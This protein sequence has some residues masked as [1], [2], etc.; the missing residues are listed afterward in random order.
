LNE[1]K[2]VNLFL[3]AGA[4]SG[5]FPTTRSFIEE[6]KKRMGKGSIEA[7]MLDDILLIEGFNDVE[8]VLELLERLYSINNHP[9]EDIF[10]RYPTVMSLP[11]RGGTPIMDVL[12]FMGSLREK[13]IDD[14]YR[15]Y[16]FDDSRTDDICETYYNLIMNL[17]ELNGSS[18]IRIFTTNYDR[19]IEKFCYKNEIEC[20]DGFAS[21]QETKHGLNPEEYGWN[22]E[23]FFQKTDVVSKKMIKLFK[24]HGSLNWR[25]KHDGR[26]V[27]IAPE[28]RARLSRQYKNNLVIYPAEKVKPEIEP[29]QT[30]H[31]IFE[32]E[33]RQADATI[34]IGFAFRDDYLNSVMKKGTEKNKVIIISP[35]ATELIKK[36]G[37]TSGFAS[38]PIAINAAFGRTTGNEIID[39]I[40]SSI[41]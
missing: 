29:F 34:F 35:H 12:R 38:N 3:G 28:E 13:L 21:N 8:H 1:T 5:W 23:Q 9:I 40:L 19:V 24:L 36:L 6:F 31:K 39:K 20:I 17:Y 33:F 18:E 27:R 30:L 25:I 15:Q 26:I 2:R 11:N 10:R 7:E 16:E 4:S 41:L 14:V 37:K 32:K 22:P